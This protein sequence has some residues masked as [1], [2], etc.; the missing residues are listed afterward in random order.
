MVETPA[1]PLTRKVEHHGLGFCD[2]Q[3]VRREIGKI[4]LGQ[5]DLYRAFW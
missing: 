5:R 1:G 4:S 3:R 2:A